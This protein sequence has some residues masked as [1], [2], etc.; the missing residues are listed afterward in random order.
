MRESDVQ[1]SYFL[2]LYNIMCFRYLQPI[3][4]DTV[5]FEVDEIK[6][7]QLKRRC[8]HPR[9][10]INIL[11]DTSFDSQQTNKRNVSSDFTRVCYSYFLVP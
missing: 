8:V 5:Y 9:E 2:C 10:R 3:S 11:P 1:Y 4:K 7:S 6:D